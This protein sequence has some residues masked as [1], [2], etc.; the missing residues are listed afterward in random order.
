MQEVPKSPVLP[1]A[2]VASRAD[3][4]L[5]LGQHFIGAYPPDWRLEE[6]L[7]L[8]LKQSHTAQMVINEAKQL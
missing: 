8:S 6:C 1:A 2:A 5:L 3:L 4:C 7:C